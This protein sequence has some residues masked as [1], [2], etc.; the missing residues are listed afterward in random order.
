MIYANTTVLGGET[1]VGENSIIAGNTFIT[2]SVQ[3]NTKVASTIP[4]LEVKNTKGDR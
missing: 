3:P 4:E 1:V 2:S